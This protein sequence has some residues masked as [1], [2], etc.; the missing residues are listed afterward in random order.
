MKINQK[1]QDFRSYINSNRGIAKPNRF[2]VEMRDPVLLSTLR[3]RSENG[4]IPNIF[5][6][7]AYTNPEE[8]LTFSA[9]STSLPSKTFST[10]P[11][12]APGPEQKYP[13]GD[14]YDDLTVTFMATVGKVP[15]FGIP[16]KRF[17]DSWMNLIVDPTTMLVN[18]SNLYSTNAF[19]ISLINDQNDILAKYRFDR[20]Y[21]IGMGAVELSHDSEEIVTFEVTFSCD[22]WQYVQNAVETIP[23]IRFSDRWYGDG[24]QA[25]KLTQSE[26]P[27]FIKPTVNS[28]ILPSTSPEGTT[29][30][31]PKRWRK[32]PQ[33]EKLMKSD[34]PYFNK[35][36][37]GKRKTEELKTT[38]EVKA[39]HWKE[40]R[41]TVQTKKLMESEAP[42]FNKPKT[43]KRKTEELKTT[44]E[45]KARH[46]KE[47]RTTVQTKKLMESEA[48]YFN[49]PKTAGGLLTLQRATTE[50][51][52]LKTL[53]RKGTRTAKK[54]RK[55]V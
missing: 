55:F 16:E 13:Y 33:T 21:P 2:V 36:K 10:N 24:I 28:N 38:P 29:T 50:F 26:S 32:S 41:T 35:P 5:P 25:N 46:W 1:L 43:G 3:R 37:T 15:N 12:D 9:R 45:V 53:A 23:D 49:K 48:P 31:I 4:A 14:V 7:V 17:F 54:L 22:R 44:P 52:Q 6:Q 27:Y 19:Y 51:K 39:R 20:L 30:A 11:V 42:Y 8:M 34:A 18:Y 40:N 47:N